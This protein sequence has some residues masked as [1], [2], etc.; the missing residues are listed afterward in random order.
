MY[1]NV[2]G[3]KGVLGDPED[4][5]EG[6][7]RKTA[8]KICAMQKIANRYDVIAVAL[9]ES[10]GGRPHIPG[11]KR[12]AL[13]D[14]EP[15]RERGGVQLHVRADLEGITAKVQD[16]FRFVEGRDKAEA[17]A[18]AFDFGGPPLLVGAAYRSPE[19]TGYPAVDGSY[20]E[21]VLCT[22]LNP[23]RYGAR[24]KSFRDW[25]GGAGLIDAHL[26][27]PTCHRRNGKGTPDAIL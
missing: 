6:R 8:E 1:W 4:E 2:Q 25:V 11:Y 21:A 15:N 24:D 17:T 27:E 10:W 7:L 20:T 22:D 18:I 16:G 12:V 26:T 13:C 19:E 23:G 5:R 3:V 9:S 14:R